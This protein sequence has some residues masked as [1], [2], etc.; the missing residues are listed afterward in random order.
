MNEEPADTVIIARLD[1]LPL[2]RFAEMWA[3][4]EASGYGFLRRVARDWESGVN[5]FSRPGEALLVAELKSRWVGICGL[6]IDP[7][8]EDPR[9]ARVRNVYVMAD[10]RRMGIGRRLVK[11]AIDRACGRFDRLRL[12]GERAH[13]ARLYELL[14]FQRTSG[15]PNC[16]HVMELNWSEARHAGDSRR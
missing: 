16:T 11:A 12:R 14:G 4:S 2:D 1:D 3:E 8:V 9:V 6:S 15:I 5:R 10:C 13:A 7:Y